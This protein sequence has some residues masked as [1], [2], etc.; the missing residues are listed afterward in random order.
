MSARLIQ[1]T[2]KRKNKGAI[3]SRYGRTGLNF[4]KIRVE[5]MEGKYDEFLTMFYAVVKK[6]HYVSPEDILKDTKK[7]ID[8]YEEV[9]SKEEED[10]DLEKEKDGSPNKLDDIPLAWSSKKLLGFIVIQKSIEVDPDKVRAIQEMPTPS[11][12]NQVRGFLGR[13][14]Y[15][16]RFISHMTATCGAI[17]KL[18]RKDQGCIWTEDFQKDF[19]NIKEYL[20]KPPILSPLVEIRPLIVYLI[21]LEESMGC[22]LGQQD[23]TGRKEHV[24]YYLSKKFTNYESRRIARWKMLLSEYDIEYR[25]QKAIKRSILADHLAH[26][27]IDDYHSNRFD[28]PDEDVM[29]LKAKDYGEPLPEEGPY[30]RSQWGLVF[31]GVINAYGNGLVAIIIIPHGSYI[32]FTARLMS[33]SL[34][35]NQIQG[36]SE[37]RH[38][39]LIPY[40]DNARRLLTFFIKVVFHHILR[41]KNYMMDALDTFSS[42]YKVNRWNEAPSI[43]II[44]LDMLA[45]VFAVSL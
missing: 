1:A 38:P 25:I 42:M 5:V 30:P 41:E 36:E 8:Q 32:P 34:V 17:F 9:K 3:A 19:N 4:P 45:H 22:V 23:E 13:L 16:S 20:L 2:C 7:G 37:T 14:N 6:Q 12:E 43:R 39:G 26:H 44:H 18:L 27:P 29:Y 40:K 31:D 28:F 33:E 10:D 24:I 35:F 21:V 15:I 11:T